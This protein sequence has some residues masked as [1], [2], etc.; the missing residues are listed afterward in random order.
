MLQLCR[1]CVYIFTM[2]WCYYCKSKLFLKPFCQ[3]GI[4]SPTSIPGK[5]WLRR[6]LREKGFYL[7]PLPAS[8]TCAP[9]RASCIAR[10]APDHEVNKR[11]VVLC[12]EPHGSLTLPRVLFHQSPWDISPNSFIWSPEGSCQRMTSPAVQ[13]EAISQPT[14]GCPAVPASLAMGL[15]KPRE[16][17]SC[18]LTFLPCRGTG[19]TTSPPLSPGM[20]PPKLTRQLQGFFFWPLVGNFLWPFQVGQEQILDLLTMKCFYLDSTK[21]VQWKDCSCWAKAPHL[22]QSSYAFTSGTSA[23]ALLTPADVRP[24]HRKLVNLS[25]SSAC[26]AYLWENVVF[27]SLARSCNDRSAISRWKLHG[28]VLSFRKS[29][30]SSCCRTGQQ[31]RAPDN[32]GYN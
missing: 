4:G 20:L 17:S 15:C 28:S 24:F 25:V 10:P 29:S 27:D 5:V 8:W 7:L 12:R 9:G 23:K 31:F 26:F 11:L 13:E 30:R 21:E 6:D 22:L 32:S 1:R 19:D 2:A 14:S 16:R 3:Y 18:F